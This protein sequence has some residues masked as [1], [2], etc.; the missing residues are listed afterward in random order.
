MKPTDALSS[1]E[2]TLIE[3]RSMLRNAKDS[4]QVTITFCVTV[5]PPSE[6]NVQV[7]C[8]T[9]G[10]GKNIAFAISRIVKEALQHIPR[11]KQ[12]KFRDLIHKMERIEENSRT[13]LS[14]EDLVR[15]PDTKLH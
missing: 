10:H 8:G 12:E 6:G 9:G 4:D 2:A 14:P 13:Y 5:T 11:A 15:C 1:L 7:A 3:V